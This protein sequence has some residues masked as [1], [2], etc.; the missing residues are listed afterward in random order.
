[1]TGQKTERKKKY[2]TQNNKLWTINFSAPKHV[3]R[4]MVISKALKK[5]LGLWSIGVTMLMAVEYCQ[6]DHAYQD[7]LTYVNSRRRAL[8]G[9]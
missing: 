8:R 4:A 3:K 6:Q 9:G 1:M 5:K 2:E 7:F